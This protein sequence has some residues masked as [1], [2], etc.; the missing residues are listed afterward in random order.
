MREPLAAP[1]GTQVWSEKSA[2]V[3]HLC[4]I[5]CRVIYQGSGRGGSA[6]GGGV[7]LHHRSVKVSWDDNAW[8]VGK[9]WVGDAVPEDRV[10]L[11]GSISAYDSAGGKGLPP[12]YST[13]LP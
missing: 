8:M 2:S 12:F 6:E 4:V 11:E 3:A 5:R 1:P 13:M 10:V 7:E 9:P